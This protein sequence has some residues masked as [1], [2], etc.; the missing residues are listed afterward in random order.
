MNRES[1]G[2]IAP[3]N[4]RG[5]DAPGNV[6]RIDACFARLRTRGAAGLFPFVTC[7]DP[8]PTVAGTVSLLHSL[9]RHGADLI[10]LGM[11]FSDPVADGPVIEKASERAIAAGVDL[12]FVLSCV[13][14]FRVGDPTTPLLLMGYINPLEQYGSARFLADAGAA[15]ADAVLLVDCPMEESTP[16]R[17]A[18]RAAGLHQILLIAPTTSAARRARLLPEA[19]GFVYYVSFKGVTGAA[20]LDTARVA[21][22]LRTLRAATT[23]PL[24]VG[25]GIRDGD[26]AAALA[27]HADAVV[28]GSALV[29][30]LA[31][32]SDS[33][34]VEARVHGFLAPI[35]RKLDGLKHAA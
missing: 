15:G 27:I 5:S 21:D 34:Q 8:L 24:A 9:V 22:E 12:H 11:P 19:L 18:L 4:G 1:S 26:T 25:F 7:G 35:R 2:E 3:I 14:E 20:R 28:I 29:E 17:P 31:G 6:N 23:V 16:L 10:E 33:A 30:S 13:R 32:A